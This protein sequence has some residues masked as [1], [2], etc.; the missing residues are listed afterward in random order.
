MLLCLCTNVDAIMVWRMQCVRVWIKSQHRIP[1]KIVATTTQLHSGREYIQSK[2][3]SMKILSQEK[4][5]VVGKYWHTVSQDAIT[6]HPLLRSYARKSQNGTR[7]RI[8]AL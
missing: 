4:E 8:I 1:E 2:V 6:A 7:K 5:N 3:G